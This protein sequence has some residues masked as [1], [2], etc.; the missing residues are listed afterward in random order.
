MGGCDY[1]CNGLGGLS[2]ALSV[3]SPASEHFK[4]IYMLHIAL[5]AYGVPRSICTEVSELSQSETKE[6]HCAWAA[7]KRSTEGIKC[8]IAQM[9]K[10]ERQL[11][12][13]DCNSEGTTYE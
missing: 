13:C 5:E 7:C 9:G 3:T 6:A 12:C 1:R 2:N 4:S 11:R 8:K 10:S